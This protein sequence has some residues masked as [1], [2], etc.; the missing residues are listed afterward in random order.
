M[1]YI[2]NI[3]SKLYIYKIF[4]KMLVKLLCQISW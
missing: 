1:N 3:V 4:Q 2:F